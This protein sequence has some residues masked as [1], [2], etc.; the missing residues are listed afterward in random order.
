MGANC[1]KCDCSTLFNEAMETEAQ[2][3]VFF[4]LLTSSKQDK[5]FKL[6]SKL[7]EPVS[8]PPMTMPS[9]NKSS[10]PKVYRSYHSLPIAAR[11]Q[12]RQ[13]EKA[14]KNPSSVERQLYSKNIVPSSGTFQGKIQMHIIHTQS[15]QVYFTSEEI[16][17]TSKNGKSFFNKRIAPFDL[18]MPVE[19]RDPFMYKSGAVYTG[20]W[21]GGF[22]WGSGKIEYTDGTIYIGQW[23]YGKPHGQGK[24][25]DS[26]KG[27]YNGNWVDGKKCGTGTYKYSDGAVYAGEWQDDIQ[28]GIGKECWD[29]GTSYEG[30]YWNGKKHGKG[31]Y[32]WSKGCE[33]FG[34]WADDN[35]QGRGIHKWA[36]GREYYGEWRDNKMDG[37]GIQKWKGNNV[38]IGSYCKDKK[39]GYGKYFWSD[40]REFH[41]WWDNNQQLG[42]GKYISADGQSFPYKYVVRNGV[43]RTMGEGK[44]LNLVQRNRSFRDQQQFTRLYNALPD[45]VQQE[46]AN[47]RGQIRAAGG[48]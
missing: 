39:H 13:T 25:I 31:R 42:L 37:I 30:Q 14:D 3:N 32:I 17:E 22:R 33:Y 18:S 20:E 23:E 1:A 11:I 26:E 29:D 7:T 36:D 41:G 43:I 9:S 6:P 38:Y 5:M 24:L 28:H 2:V 34:M 44:T 46:P 10:V 4:L 16:I 12:I 45:G 35:I 47:T 27:T 48:I 19:Q 40:G 21:K 8:E 15:M